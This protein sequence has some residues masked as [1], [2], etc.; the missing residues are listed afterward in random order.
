MNNLDDLVKR[1][2]VDHICADETKMFRGYY[3]TYCSFLDDLGHH[4]FPVKIDGYN[5]AVRHFVYLEHTVWDFISED[6]LEYVKLNIDKHLD[7]FK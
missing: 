1:K 2:L 3:F 7:L 6:D 4:Y 5:K